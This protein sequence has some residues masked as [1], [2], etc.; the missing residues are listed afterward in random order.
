MNLMPEIGIKNDHWENCDG[1][2]N[3]KTSVSVIGTV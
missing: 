3:L 2:L 1:L